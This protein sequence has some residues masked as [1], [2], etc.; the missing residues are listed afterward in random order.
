MSNLTDKM[1][2]Y[3][4]YDKGDP[5]HAPSF[6]KIEI[7]RPTPKDRELIVEVKAV[8]INPTDVVTRAMKKEE[9]TSFTILGRD[10]A[11]VVVEKGEQV[12]LFDVGD[13]VFYPGTSNI[14]G[15]QAEYHKIDERMVAKKPRNL[16]FAEAVALPLTALTGYEVLLDRLD[17]FHYE[18]SPQDTTILIVG[19]AGGAGSIA[20]QIAL[21]YGFNVVGTA[22]REESRDY[23][24]EL[25]VQHI[26]NHREPYKDQLEKIGLGTID[27]V[28]AAS[29]TDKNIDEIANIIRPQG[30]VCS[31]VPLTK[32]LPHKFF[33]KSVT[34]SY[35]LMYTR[36][37]FK[38]EDWIKQHEHLTELKNQVEQGTIQTT[39]SQRFD[40][41][42]AE[43][44]TKAYEQ[45]MTGHTT[46]KIVLERIEK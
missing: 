13:E 34:F 18:K 42:N 9:D 44:L 11:G 14:Q 25:G 37:I 41:L 19:A 29:T 5:S 2:A 1:I 23:L 12:E 46:G 6:E 21:N 36:S 30:R 20:T 15:A 39:L 33:A 4:F 27:F 16:T 8:S 24:K 17:V 28:Y 3:G 7:D 45:L 35:E 43:N 38:E 40:P 26:I 31:I 10:I 32:P 22:S